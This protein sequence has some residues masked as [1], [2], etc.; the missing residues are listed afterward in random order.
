MHQLVGAAAG[1]RV[2]TQAGARHRSNFRP[3]YRLARAAL[4][5]C[6]SFE[7]TREHV[8]YA[9]CRAG[10]FLLVAAVEDLTLDRERKFLRFLGETR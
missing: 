5:L 2:S 8:I 9:A 6:R 7:F 4:D 3:N 10:S 1:G